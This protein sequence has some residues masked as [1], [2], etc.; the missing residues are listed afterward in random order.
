[1]YR[2]AEAVGIFAAAD[3]DGIERHEKIFIEIIKDCTKGVEK[4]PS[5][6]PWRR[7]HGERGPLIQQM[8]D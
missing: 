6:S 7:C 8:R 1:V 5:I 4:N 2:R 3:E